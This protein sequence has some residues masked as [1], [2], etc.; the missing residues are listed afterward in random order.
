MRISVVRFDPKL[1]PPAEAPLDAHGEIDLPDDLLELALQLRDD[2]AYLSAAYP[3]AAAPT[4]ITESAKIAEPAPRRLGWKNW[5]S[6]G[7]AV[8]AALVLVVSLAY[9][10]AANSRETASPLTAS[11]STAQPANAHCMAA[12]EVAAPASNQPAPA[13]NGPRI[14]RL[15]WA[16]TPVL[17]EVSGPELEG[18][19]DLWQNEQQVTETRI[20]I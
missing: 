15:P 6:I 7:T 1:V 10:P 16:P 12:V 19:L 4:K 3:A 2:A 13:A 18:L 20:S 5:V 17:N 14:Q 9:R 11:P 8:A